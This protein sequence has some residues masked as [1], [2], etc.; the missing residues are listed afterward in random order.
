MQTNTEFEIFTRVTELKGTWGVETVWRKIV[1]DRGSKAG[2][3]ILTTENR[4]PNKPSGV[5]TIQRVESFVKKTCDENEI[6]PCF[7]SENGVIC[8]MVKQMQLDLFGENFPV[9]HYLD[10]E[11]P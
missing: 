6:K 7:T 8:C 1:Y 10:V 4:T 3:M 2:V 5:K 11:E 9:A